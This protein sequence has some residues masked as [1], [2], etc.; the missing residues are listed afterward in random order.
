MNRRKITSGYK[1]F[2]P[3]TI[4]RITFMSLFSMLMIVL[5][6]SCANN[7]AFSPVEENAT[8][9]VI[10]GSRISESEAVSPPASPRAERRMR[11]LAFSI[12]DSL[13]KNKAPQKQISWKPSAQADNNA[14]IKLGADETLKPQALEISV[15]IDGFRARVVIDG[16]YTNPHNRNLEGSF[17]FRLPNGAIPYFFA[18]GQTATS[19]EDDLKSPILF[20]VN[21]HSESSAQYLSQLSPQRLMIQ[22][23]QHWLAPKEAIMVSKEKAAFAYNETVAR[24]VDPALLEWSGAGVFSAKVFPLQ[25]KKTHRVVLGY[26]LD[27]KRVGGD[28]LFDLPLTSESIQKRINLFVNQKGA[29]KIVLKRIIKNVIQAPVI[30]NKN[31]E[32]VHQSIEGTELN[33]LRLTIKQHANVAL[34]GEDDAGAFFAKQWQVDLPNE[35]S[36][37]L[38]RAVFAIDTSLSASPEKFHLWVDL[39]NKILV[40]NESEI[41]E[42]ALLSFNT[43][44]HWWK[45]EFVKNTASQRKKLSKYLNQLILEGAT[46]LSSALNQ[47]TA[48]QWL[49]SD[50]KTLNSKAYDLFLLS[51]GAITWGEKKAFF[52][53]ESVKKKAKKFNTVNHL[54]TYRLGQ[55]GENASLLTHLTR[56]IGGGSYLLTHDTDINQL[57]IAHKVVP[58]KIE[59]LKLKGAN[60][61]LIAGRP[62]MVYPGQL[63]TLTGRVISELDDKMV[64]TFSKGGLSQQVQVPL[65]TRID[66]SLTSRVFGQI[67]VNQLESIET[68]ERKVASAFAN[69][70][71]VP[72]KSSSL[73]ML[74]SKADYKRYNI[75]PSEDA[76]VAGHKQV[77]QIFAQLNESFVESLSDPKKRL[78]DQLEKLEKMTFINFSMP[79][80]VSILID[81]LPQG[82]FTSFSNHQVASHKIT[83][84]RIP[85]QYLSKLNLD[86]LKYDVIQTEAN[87]RYKKYH[88]QDALKVLSSLVE[89]S[90]SDVAIIRDV[91]FA[92]E[93]W[94]LYQQAF[95]LHLTAAEL[96]P[97]EPQSYTYLAKLAQKLKKN[98]LAL[99]YFE[100]GLASKWSNRFGDYELIH[101]ID[102]V[103]FLRKSLKNEDSKDSNQSESH[104]TNFYSNNFYSSHYAKLKLKNLSREI[105]LDGSDLIVAIAWNT[106]RTDIDLHVIEP[107]GEECF[108]SHKKTQSGGFITRDVTQGFGPEMYVNKKAPK[109]KYELLVNYFSTDRNKLGLQTKVLVRTIRNWGT[110]QEVEEVR[111]VSLK[112][113]KEKQSIGKVEI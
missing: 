43:D 71:R 37:S 21:S 32:L 64:L 30:I 55:A 73:L 105:N 40:S 104:S 23:Q 2:D 70:F 8:S 10:T 50:K 83:K 5:V 17:K 76:Y 85:S 103:N 20:D 61:I 49:V 19:L 93:S 31:N 106:D 92:A 6:A 22:R 72:G 99:I 77:S 16:F 35:S 57:A 84:S 1:E 97:Y 25:A 51:D 14:V 66:S 98:D 88:S 3:M 69:H 33:G 46:D 7:V 29:E 109:G 91:A 67:A 24:Q 36:A 47:V 89:I 39:I 45:K 74:E 112:S 90:P 27:L 111:T 75:K 94:G 95:N 52:I 79:N 87:R 48:P 60:D 82:A 101:K 59:F 15:Q 56:E 12:S 18:F 81:D 41:T 13:K 26:D 11:A 110:D 113:Q 9:V 58:W 62:N 54:Y 78:K 28:L 80:A 38:P 107:S 108:Y 68:L 42:F 86:V 65:N 34:M 63:I 44:N 53:S 100:I 4:L 102:Y 96:R